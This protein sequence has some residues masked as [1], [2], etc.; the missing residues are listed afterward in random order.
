MT[1]NPVN[2]KGRNW[3]GVSHNE[4]CGW[5]GGAQEGKSQEKQQKAATTKTKPKRADE[6]PDAFGNLHLYAF[7]NL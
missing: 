2:K 4:G 3:G 5:K 1:Q 6:L 7:R